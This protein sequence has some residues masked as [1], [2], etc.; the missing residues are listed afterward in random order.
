MFFENTLLDLVARGFALA[1]MGIF[2]VVVLIRLNGLRSLSKMTNFD[3]VMTIALGSLLATAAGADSWQVFG[4]SLA[5]QAALFFVQWGTAKLRRSSDTIETVMQNA[6]VFLMRDGQFC[7]DALDTTRVA[8]S[9]VIAK[10]REANALDLD[11]VHAVVLETTGDVS[12]LHGDR[13]DERLIENVTA[14]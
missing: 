12:V 3:F 7:E 9:D 1:A 14:Q 11:K 4:Q 10:L 5:A 8:K 2:W 6:P 13:L